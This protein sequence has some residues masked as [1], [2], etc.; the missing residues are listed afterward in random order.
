MYYRYLSSVPKNQ[1]GGFMLQPVHLG[2]SAFVGE[3]AFAR[4]QKLFSR[5]AAAMGELQPLF[6]SLSFG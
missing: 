2:E 3:S 4:F 1:F 6:L 5:H